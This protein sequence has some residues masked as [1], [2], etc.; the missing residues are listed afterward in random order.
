MNYTMCYIELNFIKLLLIILN[1][2]K[3][4]HVPSKLKYKQLLQKIP[5]LFLEKPFNF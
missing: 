5:Y 1:E 4:K 3:A 2:T